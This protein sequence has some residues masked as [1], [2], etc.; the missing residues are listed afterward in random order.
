MDSILPLGAGGTWGRAGRGEAQANPGELLPTLL[1]S[2]SPV[3]T[4]LPWKSPFKECF[5][6]LAACRIPGERRKTPAPPLVL[7]PMHS[8]PLGGTQAS[9]TSQPSLRPSVRFLTSGP[10]PHPY[11]PPALTSADVPASPQAGLCSHPACPSAATGVPARQGQASPLPGP[12]L[13]RDSR[14]PSA[15]RAPR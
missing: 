6:A 14:T 8:E 9:G 11:A 12:G 13:C 15:G 4:H 5:C 3:H 1:S 7:R 10:Q 2:L